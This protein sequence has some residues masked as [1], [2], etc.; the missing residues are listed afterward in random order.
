MVKISV[1]EYARLNRLSIYKVVSM[2]RRGELEGVTVEE[3][4]QKVNY[5][6]LDEAEEEESRDET[7][8]GKSV[9][10][11]TKKS[12]ISEKKKKIEEEIEQLRREVGE[13]RRKLERCCP[14]RP[15]K[16]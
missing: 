11:K 9:V 15:E 14:D 12:S 10:E 4:G 2:I 7:A 8:S 16:V 13:L 3:N 6:V 5:V 1:K